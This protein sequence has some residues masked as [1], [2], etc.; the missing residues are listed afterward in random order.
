LQHFVNCVQQ[1]L[2]PLETG[3]DGRA[4]LEIIFAA[5]E[6]AGTRRKGRCRSR[7]RRKETG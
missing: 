6:S 7:R 3:E 1:D 2:T 4:V 5:D